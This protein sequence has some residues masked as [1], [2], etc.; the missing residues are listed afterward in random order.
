MFHDPGQALFR[1]DVVAELGLPTLE[2]FEDYRSPT[3]VAKLA[4]RFYHGPSE[5]YPV[6]EG[7]RAPTVVE[8]APGRETLEAVRRQLHRLIEDEGVR[9][10]NIAVLSG[11]TASKSEVW[12]QR[13]F[14]NVELW[15]GAIDDEG[16]SLALP[17]EAVPDEP[18][19][20]AVV[21]FESIR[22]FKGLE[23]PVVILCELDETGERFDQLLYTGMT[24]RDCVSRGHRGT[25]LGA[26][27]P[28]RDVTVAR[29]DGERYIDLWSLISCA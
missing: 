4:A 22:R 8:A 26:S 6:M 28:P 5:P 12:R 1:D 23:R 20:A 14:G 27:P 25:R 21:R 9:P 18:P 2:L 11:R 16:K 19:D 17:S 7:G 15:N 10:W 13:G 29:V 24:R 3:P